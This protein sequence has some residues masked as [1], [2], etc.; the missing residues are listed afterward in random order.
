MADDAY[1]LSFYSSLLRIGEGRRPIIKG[2]LFYYR[3]IVYRN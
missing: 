3:A 2:Q 1:G